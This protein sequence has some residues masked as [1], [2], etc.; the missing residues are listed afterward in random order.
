MADV[1]I[2]WLIDIRQ[3]WQQWNKR[4][5]LTLEKQKAIDFI[6]YLNYK[7]NEMTRSTS[8]WM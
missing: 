7:F 6:L 2:W 5:C 4:K 1:F 3:T 8:G